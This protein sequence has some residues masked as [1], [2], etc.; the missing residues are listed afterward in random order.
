MLKIHRCAYMGTKYN[1]IAFTL[2]LVHHTFKLDGVTF[3]GDVCDID[4]LHRE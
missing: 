3:L 2:N 4:T 1:C